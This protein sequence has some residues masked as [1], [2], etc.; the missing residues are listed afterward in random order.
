MSKGVWIQEPSNDG[1]RPGM[2]VVEKNGLVEFQRANGPTLVGPLRCAII[3]GG[4]AG[5][6]TLTGIAVGDSILMVA[7]FDLDGTASNI[8]LDDLT[9]EFRISA[10]DTISNTGGSD[11]TSDKLLILYM[12]LT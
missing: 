8:D 10:A 7:R 5:A 6:L 4:S 11:T 9:S 1:S 12:D 3:S 2:L